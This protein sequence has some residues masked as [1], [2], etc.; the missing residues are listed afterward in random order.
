VN[1]GIEHLRQ[2]QEGLA[3]P[4]DEF[5]KKNPTYN[6]RVLYGLQDLLKLLGSIDTDEYFQEDNYDLGRIVAS[7]RTDMDCDAFESFCVLCLKHIVGSSSWRQNYRRETISSAFTISDEAF[8]FL[9]LDN[10]R[11]YWK[12]CYDVGEH[13]IPVVESTSASGRATKRRKV[14]TR[15]T[16]RGSAG[17]M[18]GWNREGIDAYNALL[19]EVMINRTKKESKDM[20]N[21]LKRQWNADRMNHLQVAG[22]VLNQMPDG[23][24]VRLEDRDAHIVDAW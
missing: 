5:F 6:S 14:D 11:D 13:N 22:R 1:P 12:L 17:G 16:K 21:Q 24:H 4:D 20:E 3:I 10:N 7:I 23:E 2:K 8:A 18:Q 15:Y 9:V 19:K